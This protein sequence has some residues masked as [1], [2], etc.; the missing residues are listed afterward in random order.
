MSDYPVQWG[1]WVGTDDEITRGMWLEAAIDSRIY[2][3][4]SPGAARAQIQGIRRLKDSRVLRVR[5]LETFDFPYEED[6]T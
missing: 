3:Y 1:I 6:V 4:D 5:N 2:T